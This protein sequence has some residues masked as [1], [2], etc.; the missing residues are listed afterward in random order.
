MCDLKTL[1]LVVK[2]N[3]ASSDDVVATHHNHTHLVDMDTDFLRAWQLIHDLSDQLAHNQKLISTLTS[4]AGALQVGV[5]LLILFTSNKFAKS[6][7]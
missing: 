2:K 7:S 1:S 6:F 4:Q 3:V 5:Y